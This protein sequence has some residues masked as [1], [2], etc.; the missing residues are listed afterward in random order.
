MS[1]PN[2]YE[3]EAKKKHFLSGITEDLETKGDLKNTAVETV[4][5]VV[6]GVV[7]GGLLGAA[8]GRISLALGAAVTG[9]SHYTKSRLGTIFGVGLMASSSFLKPDQTVAGKEDGDFLDGAKDRLSAFKDS[10]SHR[11]FLDKVLDT[12]AIEKTGDEKTEGD[13]QYFVYPESAKNELKGTTD[14]D[15][16]DME[17]IEK[18]IAESANQYS[19]KIEERKQ[20]ISGEL[21]ESNVQ[22]GDL[23]PEDKNY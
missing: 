2:K 6:V 14:M 15:M 9:I 20:G 11:L 16:T 7:A 18:Q 23:D 4:K 19:K 21:P 12:K 13:V 10:V 5:D 17:R 1:K 22:F 3:Q 8:L